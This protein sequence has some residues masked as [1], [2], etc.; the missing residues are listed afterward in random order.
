MSKFLFKLKTIQES[1]LVRLLEIEKVAESLVN[2]QDLWAGKKIIGKRKLRK[3]K[4]LT[5]KKFATT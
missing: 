1:E 5:S 4:S 2:D 3:L